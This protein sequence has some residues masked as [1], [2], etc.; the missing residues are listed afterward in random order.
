MKYK[1]FAYLLCIFLVA[2]QVKAQVIY[3]RTYPDGF[4]S[5]K[6]AIQLSDLSTVSFAN[7]SACYF[8][9]WRH[10]GP[11]GNIIDFPEIHRCQVVL[12][13]IKRSKNRDK[14][15]TVKSCSTSG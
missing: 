2:S 6:D 4:P 13:C 1:Y 3:E 10:I 14:L 15:G 5:L 11:T 7:N 8:A 9:G 12:K